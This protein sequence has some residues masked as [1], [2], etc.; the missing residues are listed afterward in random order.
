MHG[1][2]DAVYRSDNDELHFHGFEYDHSLTG[3]DALSRLDGNLPYA[4][5]HWRTHGFTAIRNIRQNRFGLT[6]IRSCEYFS[7]SRCRPPLA[8]SQECGLLLFLEFIRFRS[9]PAQKALIVFQIELRW[10][11]IQ[12]IFA[13]REGITNF[14]QFLGGHRKEPD[15]I[16]ESQQ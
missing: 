16:E 2:D 4:C 3:T 8:L 12:R 10:L 6:V 15:L 9:N 13:L 14:E 5:R 11:D 1:F 7:A